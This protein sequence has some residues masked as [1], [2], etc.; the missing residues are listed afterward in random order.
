[1]RRELVDH[2]DVL[3]V[4]HHD[5]RPERQPRVADVVVVEHEVEVV[6]A[7]ELAG[8]AAEEHGAQFRSGSKPAGQFDQFAE[9]DADTHLVDTRADH[10][11][12]QA[13]QP[14]AAVVP[15]EQDVGH[16]HQRLD[17]VDR[18]SDCRT[19]RPGTGTGGL[20]RGSPR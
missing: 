9:R 12:R 3:V 10:G 2:V 18:R 17:V 1:M 7:D 4:H 16:V 13:E 14:M 8:R 6:G 20:L 5:A 19:G 15:V 11:T